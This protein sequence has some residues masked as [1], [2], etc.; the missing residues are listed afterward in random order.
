MPFAKGQSG[1]PAG[2]PAGSRNR[3]TRE[4]D[5]AL[6]HSGPGLIGAI[7]GH[8]HDANP[9]AMRLCLDRLV[10]M[11]KHRPSAVQLPPV[12][13]PN[14]TM[15][16]LG[17]VQRALGAGEITTDEATRLLGFVERTTRILASKAQAQIELADR[18]ARCEE[19]LLLLL[20]AA[21]VAASK[22][23]LAPQPAADAAIANNNA[24]TMMPAAAQAGRPV[25]AS[26]AER[27]AVAKNNEI[28]SAEAAAPGEA[29]RAPP[30][31]ARPRRR[32]G[33]AVDR[34]LG[35]TSPLAHLTGAMPAKIAPAMPPRVP[36]AGAA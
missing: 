8:V 34:L 26:P 10:P 18:L 24:E 6:Q 14:Y 5:E 1:N 28:G 22:A 33:G 32:N 25:A 17:E 20:G 30:G 36:L 23:E 35:S 7:V 2:R 21:P 31:E 12:D 4:M 16:A 19:A 15:A 3:F 11:G 9:A 27:P 29:L 13:S